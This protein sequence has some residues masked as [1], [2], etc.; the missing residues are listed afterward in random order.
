MVNVHV[1]TTNLDEREGEQIRHVVI[2]HDNSEHRK[3]LGKHCFWAFRN[4]HEIVTYPTEE[5]V[6][7]KP[8]RNGM[9][10]TPNKENEVSET[11]Q[12]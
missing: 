1:I 11:I 9:Y 4:N 8:K 5:E 2:D 7:F 6:T 3:W 10:S 12:T